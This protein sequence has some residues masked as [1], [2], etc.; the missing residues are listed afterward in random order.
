LTVVAKTLGDFIRENIKRDFDFDYC[1]FPLL[2]HHASSWLW[3]A[4]SSD[5]LAE[6]DCQQSR[7]E[8]LP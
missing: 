3:S 4:W 8:P 7:G 1:G 2:T 6:H 5:F